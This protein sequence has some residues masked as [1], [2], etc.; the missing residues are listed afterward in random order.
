[1]GGERWLWVWIWIWVSRFP[2]LFACLDP[3]SEFELL[4]LLR[5]VGTRTESAVDRIGPLLRSMPARPGLVSTASAHV[6]LVAH[7][8][9]LE[10]RD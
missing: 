2:P 4:I 6:Y 5:T 1:V 3:P 9:A 8:E 10:N 7:F